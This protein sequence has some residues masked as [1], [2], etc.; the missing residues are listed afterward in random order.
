MIK[1]ALVEKHPVICDAI[2]SLLRGADEIEISGCYQTFDDLYKTIRMEPVHVVLVLFY[3]S[4]I[5]NID[6]IKRLTE[7]FPKVKVLV[8]SL[9]NNEKFILK[10]IKAGA[11]GHL[12]SD[13]NRSEILEAIYTLRNGYEFYAKTITNILLNSYL[14]QKGDD[15]AE[16]QR[17]QKELSPRELEVLKN[18]GEGLSNREIADK[19]FISIRTVE[20]HKNNI[21]KKINLKTTVDLVK[22]ALKNNIIELD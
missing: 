21:M 1:V 17:R 7:L 10:L 5:A 14:A 9:Y 3:Q 6:N 20:T 16:K 2:S 15:S 8:L 4:D 12:S 22:F 19:L 13:T 18:F 11:K